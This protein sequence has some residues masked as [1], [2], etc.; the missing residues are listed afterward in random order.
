[1]TRRELF[2]LP[3]A[4][5]WKREPRATF[6][7]STGVRVLPPTTSTVSATSTVYEGY[8]KFIYRSGIVAQSTSGSVSTPSTDQ[9]WC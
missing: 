4:L 9:R 3:L 7:Y 5:F 1:M 2:A 6:I 8:G